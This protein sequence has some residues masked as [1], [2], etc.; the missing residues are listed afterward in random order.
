MIVSRLRLGNVFDE[1]LG[2]R[3][4][5]I[6]GPGLEARDGLARQQLAATPAVASKVSARLLRSHNDLLSRR[7]RLISSVGDDDHRYRSNCRT[8]LDDCWPRGQALGAGWMERT[9]ICDAPTIAKYRACRPFS[10]ARAGGGVGRRSTR[11][12]R[13]RR[14][15]DFGR[16]IILAGSIEWLSMHP[17]ARADLEAMRS[18]D[19]SLWAAQAQ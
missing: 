11:P 1:A 6:T 7:P 3:S 13:R 17:D 16:N 19:R 12:T 10:R 15:P 18:P 9:A 8:G 14:L 4:A 5:F 2:G